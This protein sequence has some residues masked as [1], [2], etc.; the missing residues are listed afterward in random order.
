M[1]GERG[2]SIQDGGCWEIGCETPATSLSGTGASDSLSFRQVL[3]T[4]G[5]GFQSCDHHWPF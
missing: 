1:V 3:G 2:G 4:G 5:W